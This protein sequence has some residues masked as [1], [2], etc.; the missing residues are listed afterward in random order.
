[1]VQA[2][3]WLRFYMFSNRLQLLQFYYKV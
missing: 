1:M 2:E 3:A